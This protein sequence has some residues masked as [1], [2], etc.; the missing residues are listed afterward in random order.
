[1]DQS[2]N[3]VVRPPLTVMSE[4][5]LRREGGWTTHL[6][7][8]V[9]DQ[10][11]IVASFALAYWMRYLAE[12]PAVLKP[13]ISEVE[14]PNFVPFNAF[15]PI[16]LLMVLL[17]T[18][19][20]E[21]KGLYRVARGSGWIDYASIILSSTLTGIALLIVFVFLYRPFFYSRLIFAFAGINIIVLLC[22]WRGVLVAIRHWCW[23]QGIGQEQVLVVGGNGLGQQVM[24]GLF[25]QPHQGYRLVGYLEDKPSPTIQYRHCPH[26]GGIHDLKMVV[27]NHRVNLVILALPYWLQDRLPELA[28]TCRL[29]D[30]DFRIAP[31]L[32]QL[33][34]DRVDVLQVSGVPLIGL[35]A[36][37][38]KGWN[39]ALKRAID[40][41]LVLLSAPVTLP[42]SLCIAALIRLDSHG[43]ALFRQTRVGKHGEH[44]T[45]YKFR[46][47]VVDA[48]KRQA[49][50]TAL[51]EADGP[52]FKM[53]R[54][55][56][57]TRVGGLLRRSSLDELPQ[58]LN[59][60]LGDMSLVGPRPGLPTEVA[61]YE[62]WHHRR[63]EVMPGLT[64]LWQVLGRSNTTFDEM[65]RLD[66]YYAENW[67]VGMD[68]RIIFQTVPA[69]LLSKG[70]Y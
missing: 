70:A 54:D 66:I 47:M 6:L 69:V 57:V 48:E 4:H 10:L 58:L 41:G 38:I 50:L 60:L 51:N 24:N 5:M 11:L 19:L 34:F 49:E 8:L 53:K 23:S 25:A 44:F 56:R 68:L 33:S 37:S 45:C 27:T 12:W 21:I 59:V 17:L 20:F 26:L 35:K 67:S 62:E 65:V 63:L 42:L 13:V 18:V 15:L 64:G 30:I 3:P 31:D 61:C 22:L 43:P 28:Q 14:T 36:V 29:L 40:V 1:M 16:T 52:L 9:I 46:T 2:L 39:L 7:S 32:Y 55:P